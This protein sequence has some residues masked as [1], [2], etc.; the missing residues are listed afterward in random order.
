MVRD[1]HGANHEAPVSDQLSLFPGSTSASGD[2]ATIR[3]EDL[4]RYADLVPEHFVCCAHRS[5]HPPVSTS[6][7]ARR[8]RTDGLRRDAGRISRPR[9]EAIAA[10]LVENGV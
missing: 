5:V 4:R 9:A 7:A 1:A 2:G 10:R 3:E 8:A 6:A